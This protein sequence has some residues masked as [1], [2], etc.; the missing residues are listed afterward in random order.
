[1]NILQILSRQTF[2]AK[3]PLAKLILTPTSPSGFRIIQ[4]ETQNP[5]EDFEMDLTE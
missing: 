2:A 4:P 5:L 3:T 1:L